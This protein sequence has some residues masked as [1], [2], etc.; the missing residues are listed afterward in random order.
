MSRLRLG[1]VA[2]GYLAGTIPSAY[3]AAR[4]SGAR[5]VVDRASASGSG[6]D[7]HHLLASNAGPAVAAGAMAG[8]VAKAALVAL[9][10]RRAGLEPGW[11]AATAVAAVAGHTFPFYARPFAGR[12]LAAAAGVTLVNLP[13]EMVIAGSVLLAGKALGHTGPGS[14]LGFA[15]VPVVAAV[16]GRPRAMV[17]MGACVFGIIL[18][19]RLVGVRPGAARDGWATASARRL[20]FDSDDAASPRSGPGNG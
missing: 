8:D 18:A 11:R 9:A 14:T 3:V 15:A 4:L 10:A 16:R 1:W 6:G 17:A 12:G 2:A 13:A 19:R 7:A 5:T 20:F